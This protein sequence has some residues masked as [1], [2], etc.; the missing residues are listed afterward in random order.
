M[1][2]AAQ[3]TVTVV[4]GSNAPPERLEACLAALEPQREGVEVLVREGLA[5][6]TGLRER[7][8]WAHYDLTPGALVPEH[9][10]D[11]ID[12]A[13]GD[14]VA[15]TIAQMIPEPDW[16]ATI[17]RLHASH[18]V[19]G[20]AIDPGPGLRLVDWG[21]FFCRY[22]R[23]MR[24]FEATANVELAGDNAAYKRALLEGI[25]ETYR[26]GFWEPVSHR[27][28][29][30]DGVVLW[31]DP[32]LVVRQGRSAGF[33]AFARQ[34]LEHGR[35]YGHQRGRHFSKLRNAVGVLAAPLV[36]VLMTLRVL[37]QVFGKRRHRA[38]AILALPVIV[39]YNT[40]WA[41]AEA[42]GHADVLGR[43]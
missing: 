39:A 20:G 24:P 9:W 28:L 40:V 22:A 29:A 6:P 25:A 35:R 38:R 11:G 4:I 43:R 36:P 14:I 7:F 31:H 27:R 5:S 12:A 1:S 41:Y 16:V 2:S 30:E 13:T 8:P 23:D 33:A 15:L 37:R 21:E 32:S 3:P 17:R 18:H 10:R 42:R 34:R 26:E 19:V